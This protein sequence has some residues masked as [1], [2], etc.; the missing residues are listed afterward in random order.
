MAK[1]YRNTIE[2]S[3]YAGK[4]LEKASFGRYKIQPVIRHGVPV[5]FHRMAE[6]EDIQME[7]GQ[8]SM[9]QKTGA[10][11][12]M[13]EKTGALHRMVQKTAELVME[14]QEKGYNT[15]AVICRTS[16][17]AEQVEEALRAY[18]EI[19]PAK[20]L[21]TAEKLSV[22]ENFLSAEESEVAVENRNFSKGVMVLPIHLTK[23]L[24]FDSVILWNPDKEA[25][26][27]TEGDAKLLYVAI[28]RALHEL[29]IVYEKELTGLLE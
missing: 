5:A 4:V 1:S 2:I 15:I 7:A 28:T 3:E 23:G 13:E 17:E 26:R 27:N 16:K 19:F 10:L 12:R 22:A 20:K 11:H 9:I 8:H 21:E 29:H 24:E 6:N 18:P 14:I 25:Y